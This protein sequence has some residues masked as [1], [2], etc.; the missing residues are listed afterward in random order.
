MHGD[1]ESIVPLLRPIRLAKTTRTFPSS[2]GL[3]N[4]LTLSR[5]VPSMPAGQWRFLRSRRRRNHAGTGRLVSHVR[6]GAHQSDLGARIRGRQ[7]LLDGGVRHALDASRRRRGRKPARHQLR[8]LQPGCA[9]ALAELRAVALRHRVQVSAR[10][11][12]RRGGARSRS[13]FVVDRR[14]SL[15]VRGGDPD[16]RSRS[17]RVLVLDPPVSRPRDGQ[18]HLV[19]FGSAT[20]LA[21]PLGAGDRVRSKT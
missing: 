20:R 19:G 1:T 12:R 11:G 14:G 6:D 18:P 15:V 4:P 9:R 3:S 5:V 7:Q 17:P 16:T 8:V 10:F 21:R 13:R 2:R